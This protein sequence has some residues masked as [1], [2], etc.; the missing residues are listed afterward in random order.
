MSEVKVN[1][2]ACCDRPGRAAFTVPAKDCRRENRAAL[3]RR[4]HFLSASSLFAACCLP[5]SSS[6]PCC[7][8][9]F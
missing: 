1:G 9:S 2:S 4:P 6:S 8:A 3:T 5:A 7:D